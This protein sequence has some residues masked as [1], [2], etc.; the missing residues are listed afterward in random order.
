MI[1]CLH[2]GDQG[3]IFAEERRRQEHKEREAEE[4]EELVNIGAGSSV[5]GA[6]AGM[7]LATV[8][9]VLS[10]MYGFLFASIRY[11]LSK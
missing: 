6:A 7:P 4:V 11:F 10:R 3:A 2:F 9:A 1:S 5:S 8:F